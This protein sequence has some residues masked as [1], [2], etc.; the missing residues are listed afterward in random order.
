MSKTAVRIGAQ[1]QRRWGLRIGL[2]DQMALLGISGVFVTGAICTAALNYA[3][4]VE[5]VSAGSNQ[6]KAHVA[7]LSQSFLE[8]K[9][10]A[11]DFLSK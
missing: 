7:S 9:Q 10:I 6:F 4:V 2:R 1:S 8:S 11:N 5:R 3:S